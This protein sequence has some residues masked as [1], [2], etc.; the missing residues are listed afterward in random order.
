VGSREAPAAVKVPSHLGRIHS[1]R[2]GSRGRCAQDPP[3]ASAVT[4]S[5]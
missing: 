5:E 1:R 4:W 2:A 3:D